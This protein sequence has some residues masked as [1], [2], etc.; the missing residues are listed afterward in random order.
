MEYLTPNFSEEML[1]DYTVLMPNMAPIQFAC[2]KPA[3]ESEGYHLEMLDNQGSEVS[4]LGLKYVHNDTCYPALLIIGQFLDALN[5]GKYDVHHTA[6][7]ISQSGGGCRASNYIK[8]LRKALVKAGYD[9]VPVASA[10]VSGLEKGSTMPW[11]ARMIAKALAGVEY[12]DMLACLRNQIAPYENHP[13]D[14]DAWCQKWIDKISYWFHHNHNFS[15]RAMHR[16][17]KLIAQDATTIPVTKV[18]KIKVGIVGEIYVKFSPL[19]NNNLQ[20][21]LE[22]EGCE[23]NVPGIMGYVCYCCANMK[24][25]EKLYGMSKMLGYGGKTALNFFDSLN[26]AASK[27]MKDAG[28]YAPGSFHEL[29][30]KPKGILS[31]GVKMGEGWLLTGEIVELIQSGYA[32]IVCAQ[33]F[34]CLPN[35]IAGK[36][37]INRIW[38]LYPSANITAVDYDPSST[39]VNQENR[40]KLM[41]SVAKEN[42]EKQKSSEMV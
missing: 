12:G 35:H 20:Q 26:K 11:N 27:A 10:N 19:G 25:D 22:D 34:G 8:L 6:I 17:F 31:L 32:N 5:S 2:I 40:I 42:L 16:N 33:P 30:K 37:V 4:Q 15:P 9:Y 24:I 18:D 29:M 28:F 14:A 7:L 13:G 21:F 41:L 36:G 38:S 23:V 3:M 1:K 39:K